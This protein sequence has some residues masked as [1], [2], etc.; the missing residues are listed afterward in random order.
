MIGSLRSPNKKT[1]SPL[2]GSKTMI[3]N[4]I[5]TETKFSGLSTAGKLAV[6][7]NNEKHDVTVDLIADHIDAV[8]T[9]ELIVIGADWYKEAQGYAFNLANQFGV[10]AHYVIGVIAAVSPRQ[11]WPANKRFAEHIL[12]EF[13]KHNRVITNRPEDVAKAIGGGLGANILIAVRILQGEPIE[14]VLTGVKRRSFYNNI[15]SG[16][17]S[18]CDDVTVDTWMQRAAMSVSPDQGMS[19]DDSLTYLGARKKATNGVGAGYIAIADAVRVVAERRNLSTATVQAGY[20]I[21]RAGS[22]HGWHYKGHGKDAH[23]YDND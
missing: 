21:A 7:A 8:L 12:T 19:L 23:T 9:D 10:P 4:L 18:W 15:L 17:E 13:P 11:S 20:W 5:P 3:G 22:V 6:I 14:S 1:R 2:N 16:G